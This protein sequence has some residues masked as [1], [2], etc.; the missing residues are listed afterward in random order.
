MHDA[1]EAGFNKIIFVIRKDIHKDFDEIIGH[2]IAKKCEIEYAFQE[3]DDLPKGCK[4]PE[5]RIKPWGTGQ[6]V[7]ACRGLTHEP[8]AI[9]NAD[10]YYGKE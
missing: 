8:F 2:R 4:L 3:L 1:L 7:L 10:D 5:G 9:I 6:A